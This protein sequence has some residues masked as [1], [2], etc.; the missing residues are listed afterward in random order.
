MDKNSNDLLIDSVELVKIDVKNLKVGMFVSKLDRPWLETKFL[1][2]GFELRNQTDIENVQKQ[3]DFVFIDVNKQSK[4][5]QYVARNTG[6]TKDYLEHVDPP[7]KRTSFKQEIKRAGVIHHKA[8]SLV[9]TFME[10]VQLGRP[11]NAVAAKKA[12]SAC[13]DSVL[14]A[15]DALLLMTQL[16]KRDEYTAQHSM[17][18]CIYSIALGRQINLSTEELNNVGLC[19]MMHD[20][21]KMLVPLDI[22]NKPGQLTTDELPVMQSHTTK[23]WNLLL[24]TSGLYPGAIDVAHMHHER[25]DGAGYPRKLSAEQITPYSRIVAIADMYDAVSSDRVYKPGKSH[26]EAIKIMTDVSGGHLDPALTMKFIECLGIY[27]AGSIVEL[28][29]G[30]IAL[31]LEV[32]PKAKLKPRIMIIQ[33]KLNKPCLEY[34]VDLAMVSQNVDG[35]QFAIKRVLRPEECGVD[36]LNYLQGGLF[37][38][39]LDGGL[40][41]ELDQN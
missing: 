31:V 32:N 15:P 41:Q 10:E 6:Y 30:Q 27:P 37:E 11:I 9:K 35:R 33:E 18:V 34:V 7:G 23:G 28:A 16:K 38:K 1:F 24:K 13:V 29:S 40:H 4:V 3:C 17:N 36:L 25:L 12:V 21:G 39:L 5:P 20:M 26:L 2:Q 14:N 8:S 22:L 19:G